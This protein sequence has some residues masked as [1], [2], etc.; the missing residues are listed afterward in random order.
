MNDAGTRGRPYSTSAFEARWPPCPKSLLWSCPSG[1]TP[2]VAD[3]RVTAL[4]LFSGM[5]CSLVPSKHLFPGSL[6]GGVRPLIAGRTRTCAGCSFQA[7][8]LWVRT[9]MGVS[10]WTHRPISCAARP[11]THPCFPAFWS[12][13][14]GADSALLF[15]PLPGLA[16][17]GE[18]WRTAPDPKPPWHYPGQEPGDALTHG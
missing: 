10:V 4:C 18:R 5:Q 1:H 12:D 9:Q 11:G 8:T 3:E 7:T 15:P 14:I 6:R 2:A 17:S 16:S 13:A